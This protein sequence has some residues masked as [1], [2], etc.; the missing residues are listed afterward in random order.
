MNNFTS[1]LSD[2]DPASFLHI[3]GQGTAVCTHAQLWQ[4]LQG[5]V[6]HWLRHDA[7]I[8]GWGDF[9][10]GELQYD[11]VSSVPGLRSQHFTRASIAPLISYLRD[12]WVAAQQSPC[13][14][15]ITG[16]QQ[17]LGHCNWQSTQAIASMR[18]ALV[19]GTTDGPNGN[20]RIYAALSTLTSVPTGGGA[21][22]KLL[23]PFIDIAL[24]RIPPAPA[25]Q[26]ACDRAGVHNTTAP[27]LSERERQIMDW[28]ALGKTNPEI[29]CILRISEFTVKNHLKSIF[30]KL[31]VSNR[32][33]AVAKL[34]RT[35]AYA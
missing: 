16:C 12:C 4:W 22:L 17:L 32:A 31:D 3:A 2:R 15:D 25:R 33:Q 8:V 29:G 28:V 11:I 18:T 30:T 5:D 1:S 26:A 19:H 24:R 13:E 27:A 14:V 21:A 7:L 20:E 34:S 9:R 6:Q 35:S 23:M 10:T